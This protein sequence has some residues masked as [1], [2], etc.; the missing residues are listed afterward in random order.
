M[1]SSEGI[2]ESLTT[3]ANEW[4]TLALG[5]R[6]LFATVALI[7]LSGCRPS[8]RLVAVLLASPVIS[9]G[10][11]AWQSGN[12]FNGTVFAI[13]ALALVRM[14]RHFPSEPIAFASR[15][16]V[17][18]GTVL[19]GFGW[20][21]PH[22]LEA[23]PWT[24]Y[25]YEA[26]LGLIP[27]PTLLVVVGG[28]LILCSFESKAWAA[29]VTSAALVYGM[30]GVFALGVAMDVVLLAGAIV[31]GGTAVFRLR[32]TEPTTGHIS[33]ASESMKRWYHREEHHPATA[34]PPHEE[35]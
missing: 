8:T 25:L 2:L 5:W 4:R 17:V 32:P 20:V 24:S 9:V 19:I 15:P 11:L 13:L 3:V 33:A 26:P 30:I 23:R 31:L 6:V 18:T 16:L 12:P 22:F 10:A 21:Y 29:T 28:S 1:A 7:V 27:C 14:A 35:L 34:N